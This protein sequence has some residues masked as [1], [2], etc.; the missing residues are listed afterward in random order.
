[1]DGCTMGV[2][3]HFASTMVGKMLRKI[4]RQFDYLEFYQSE[5]S[6]LSLEQ[7]S[8]IIFQE[9]FKELKLCRNQLLL[10]KRELLTTLVFS[11]FDTATSTGFIMA[12]GDGLIS[13]NGEITE[14]DQ[15]NK[16]DYVGF[17]LDENFEDWYLAQK[18]K[19]KLDSVEDVSIATDGILTFTRILETKTPEII[20]PISFMVSEPITVVDEETLNKRLKTIEHV[21]GL[22]P[23]DDFAMI[24]I[25]NNN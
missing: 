6:T 21:Y 23:S 12:V 25:V 13:I 8:K 11:I 2:D 7:Y 19:I 17:H 10:D 24:R 4:C 3:S 9:L 15:D 5:L 22:K 16:P 18:Q 1:M 14:F 20:D